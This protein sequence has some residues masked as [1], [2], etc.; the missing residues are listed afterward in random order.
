MNQ[1]I[2]IKGMWGENGLIKTYE[3][4]NYDPSKIIG[5]KAEVTKKEYW[6]FLECLP[7]LDFDGQNFYLQEFITG[8]LTF[9]FTIEEN[10]YFCE[11]KEFAGSRY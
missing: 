1:Q 5:L 3:G 11:I 4:L 10:K 8:N 7:P 6:H 2:L 9:Y